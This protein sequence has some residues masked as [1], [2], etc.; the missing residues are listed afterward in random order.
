MSSNRR[1]FLT[2]SSASLGSVSV[3]GS[4]LLPPFSPGAAQSLPESLDSAT[5]AFWT[6][7]VRKPSDAFARGLHLQGGPAFQ[8]EFVYYDPAHGFQAPGMID[9]TGFPAK[10]SVNV[11]VRVARFR[12]SAKSKAIFENVQGGSLRVD[13][14][15]TAPM[16]GLAEALAWTAVAALVPN[17]EGK[18]PDLKDLS[19]DPGESWGK[20]QQTPLTNGL[21]FWSWN[22]FLKRKDSLWGQFVN[23]FRQASKAV[24][25]LLGLPAIAATALAGVDKILGWIQANG[26]SDWLFQS[27][28]SPVYATQEGKA[29]IGQGLP[30]KTGQYLVI[31]R[32]QLSLFGAARANL[33]LRDGY[34]VRKGTDPFDWPKQAAREIADVD[35][36][37]LYVQV[38]PST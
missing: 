6:S 33:E 3:L 8:P 31:P 17:S 36:L 13:L 4:L 11:S 37:S 7:E 20:L 10:G 30:L 28:D 35:Y 26:K 23:L 32:D 9:D 15:Q 16:P 1:E 27:V 19:F 14:K 34:L 12:P 18:L 29:A 21:G 2:S 25:P 24:V 22:F 5:L 38:R